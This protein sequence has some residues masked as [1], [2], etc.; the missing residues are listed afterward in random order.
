[1]AIEEA[2]SH[3]SGDAIKVPLLT[4]PMVDLRSTRIIYEVTYRD[5]AESVSTERS[6]G[7]ETRG[8]V[9]E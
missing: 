3:I 4:R 9:S 5:L 7:H 8:C 6:I 1:M 2:R